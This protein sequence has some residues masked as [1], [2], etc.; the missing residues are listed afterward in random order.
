MVAHWECS[1]EDWIFQSVPLG[2]VFGITDP[3][4]EEGPSEPGFAFGA[5][6]G[7]RAQIFEAG[8]RF[9]ID[10][11]PGRDC[12]MGSETELNLRLVKEGFRVWHCKQAV[13]QH[14]VPTSK[15]DRRW[16]LDRAFKFGREQYRLRGRSAHEKD[17]FYRGIPRP[18]INAILRGAL[19]SGTAAL[20]GNSVGAF[21]NIWRFRYLLGQAHEARLGSRDR[22]SAVALK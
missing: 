7:I 14:F 21:R 6:I 10:I 15:M 19:L 9:D 17:R 8:Y 2:P 3:S 5:N 13:V 18:L 22:I 4:W 20:R 16:I 12:P 11:G 1:P